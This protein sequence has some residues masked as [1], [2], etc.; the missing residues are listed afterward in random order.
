[1]NYYAVMGDNTP[2][3]AWMFFDAGKLSFTGTT[4]PLGSLIQPPQSFSFQLVASDVVGFSGAVLPFT[5]VV[6]SHEIGADKTSLVLNATIDGPISYPGLKSSVR[7]DGKPVKPGD[8]VAASAKGLPDWLSWIR[9]AGRSKG[10]PP[11]KANVTTFVI[12][13]QDSFSD[14]LNITVLVNVTDG[15]D[16]LFTG[17][18]PELDVAP[19]HHFSQELSSSWP[20]LGR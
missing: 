3:P 12:S 2:L 16:K 8:G 17:E 20:T 11:K 9:T 7:L 13:L 5:F 10:Q 1:M 4:P 6:G 19:G 14:T 15:S 18:L